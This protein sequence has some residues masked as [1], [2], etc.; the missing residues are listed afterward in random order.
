MKLLTLSR[1]KER[2]LK[3]ADFKKI[4]Y[5]EE[6][7]LID[8]QICFNEVKGCKN[9]VDGNTG[10]ALEILKNK[11]QPVSAPLMLKLERQLCQYTVK[12]NHDP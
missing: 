5:V 9:K 11:F 10:M 8:D 4:A 3:T 1:K 6:I 7:I 2:T 12:K